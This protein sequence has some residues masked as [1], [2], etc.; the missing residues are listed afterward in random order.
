MPPLTGSRR[1]RSGRPPRLMPAPSE[2]HPV[3]LQGGMKGGVSPTVVRALI[4]APLSRSSAIASALLLR[5]AS[6]RAV[7]LKA[8]SLAS[9]FA[10]AS[11]RSRMACTTPARAD[12]ISSVS[13]DGAAPFGSAPAASSA[14]IM[15][16]LPCSAATWSGVTRYRLVAS[17]FAPRASRRLATSRSSCITAASRGV[18]P[19]L[20]GAST[21]AA[22]AEPI[23][24]NARAIRTGLKRH[25]KRDMG[26]PDPL[27]LF[28][29]RQL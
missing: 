2:P 19:S 5:A 10:P 3:P 12:V 15:S 4:S 11:M 27:F 29:S 7:W 21:G 22:I 14:A 24:R 17:A 1:P 6:I 20:L 26:P 8:G 23:S 9:I 28:R 16:V 13:P 25:R 18:L